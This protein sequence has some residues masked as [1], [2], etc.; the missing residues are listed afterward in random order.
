ADDVEPAAPVADGALADLISRAE[1]LLGESGDP[2]LQRLVHHVK[3]LLDDGFNPVVFCRYIGS[4]GYVARALDAKWKGV[5]FGV[6]TGELSA[7]EREEQVALL[8]EADRRV[9]VATDCL[10]EGINLQDN[11]DAVVHYDLSWNPTRHEQ[12]EGRVDRFGQKA[13]AVRAT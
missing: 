4:A 9:L 12:R 2:K 7:E 5:T 13:P 6:V 10:S 11:F 8:G 1:A 3:Q